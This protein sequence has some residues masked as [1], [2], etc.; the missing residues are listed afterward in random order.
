MITSDGS[1]IER[2]ADMGITYFDT[3]RGYQSGNNERMVGAAL[4]GKRKEHHAVH[5]DRR[6]DQRGS[7]GGP[8][9]QPARSWARTTWISGT[10]TARA[11]PA[12]VTDELIEAQ[13]IA[14]KAGKIR[15]AGVSTHSGQKEL[16]PV[17]GQEP[18]HR[19]D[20][21]RLQLHHGAVHERR[22]RRGAPRPARASWP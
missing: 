6:R 4:K 5:Q 13:Q 14:K 12:E 8:R 2:A 15:F 18:E 9:H 19:R 22:H 1:V 10:C 16:I 21:D 7:A 11:T 17:A 3:A 20:P